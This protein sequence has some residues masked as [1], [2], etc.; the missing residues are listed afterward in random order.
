MQRKRSSEELIIQCIYIEF[1]RSHHLQG[2]TAAVDVWRKLHF[3]PS[4]DNLYPLI[5]NLST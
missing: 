3:M 5:V 4:I 2:A 1:G